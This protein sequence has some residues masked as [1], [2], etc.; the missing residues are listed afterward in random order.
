L[1]NHLFIMHCKT[2][3]FGFSSTSPRI[4]NTQDREKIQNLR[5]WWA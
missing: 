1:H 2:I 4:F 3:K 5:F